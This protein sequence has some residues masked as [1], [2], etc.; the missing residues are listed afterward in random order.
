[1]ESPTSRE[2]LRISDLKNRA[3]ALRFEGAYTFEDIATS[4]PVRCAWTI[5]SATA[6]F[7]VQGQVDGVMQL[8]CYRCLEPYTV[9]VALAIDE[10]YVFESYTDPYE[11]EKELVSDDFFEVVSEAGELDLK[12][13]A[14]Q[15]LVLELANYGACGRAACGVVTHAENT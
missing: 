14:H 3:G 8:D 10:Q 9:P 1:M 5:A 7:T 11:R 12:D 13:L 2:V 6:G 15:F 4:E